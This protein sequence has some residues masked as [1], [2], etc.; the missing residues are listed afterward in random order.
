M[1]PAAMLLAWLCTPLAESSDA[2]LLAQASP[3]RMQER[4]RRIQQRRRRKAQGAGK[5]RG[6]SK[7]KG[8]G[9]RKRRGKGGS[10]EPVG[11]SVATQSSGG[12]GE[13]DG[14]PMLITRWLVFDRHNSVQAWIDQNRESES[15]GQRSLDALQGALHGTA[16]RHNEALQWLEGAVGSP[17]YELI[18]LRYEASSLLALGYPQQALAL[19]N[20][21]LDVADVP[22]HAHS[23][24]RLDRAKAL[25]ELG[26]TTEAWADTD[27]ETANPLTSGR[28]WTRQ[29]H[30]CFVEEDLDCAWTVYEMA[31]HDDTARDNAI[32]AARFWL[33]VESGLYEDAR[34]LQTEI[35]AR[36]GGRDHYWT[37][38]LE[39]TLQDD[40]PVAA[41]ELLDR[42]RFTGNDNPE[43][44]AYR[45]RAEHMLGTETAAADLELLAADYPTNRIIQRAWRAV[46]DG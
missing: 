34:A 26:Y 5:Y 9:K 7:G 39:L 8:K 22:D 2:P 18:G 25:A 46:R 17:Y 40:D 23:A 12:V 35:G 36:H 27:V 11:K 20:Q 10:T 41:L 19:W 45:L 38:R 3:E 13:V 16:G 15:V 32:D 24:V 43:L 6:K 28:A 42:K 14:I 44:L 4:R 21:Y 33:L 1:L 31:R 37:S 29:L 30:L